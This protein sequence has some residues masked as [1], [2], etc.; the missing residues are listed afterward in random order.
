MVSLNQVANLERGD[1]MLAYAKNKFNA[2]NIRCFQIQK[3]M[4]NTLT[5]EEIDDKENLV[6][7]Q[8]YAPRIM[9][10]YF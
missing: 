1:K 2:W 9:K 10:S 5:A 8:G 3:T 4:G 7:K 6:T